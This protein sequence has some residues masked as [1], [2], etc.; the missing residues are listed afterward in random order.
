MKTLDP[1][2]RWHELGE[3]L[4]TGL[5]EGLREDSVTR[6]SNKLQNV[7]QHIYEQ[8]VLAL[9]EQAENSKLDPSAIYKLIGL[10]IN[11]P[12]RIISKS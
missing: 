10:L 2:A 12:G 9:P 7:T 3:K 4:E 5:R 8:A 11:D 6:A 1:L